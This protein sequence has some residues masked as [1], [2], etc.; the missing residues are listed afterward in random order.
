MK[1]ADALAQ[2]V[3]DGLRAGR[4]P[5]QLRAALLAEGWSAPEVDRALGA[6]ADHGLGLP[7]PRP[8][9]QVASGEAVLY[10]LMFVALLVVIWHLID[11]GFDLISVWLPDPVRDSGGV[12]V[13]TSIRWSIAALVVTVPLFLWLNARVERAVRL[14]PATARAPLRR[15]FGALTLFLAALSLV[16]AAVSVVYGGLMGI[17]TAHFLA[18]TALV[19]VIAVLVI[20]YFRA[21]VAE[22]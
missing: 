20:G 16:G 5:A 6:W 22:D 17:V 10:G 14:D 1:P 4:A 19:V 7:V 11:L 15:R 8:R 9:V 21:Y 3:Q 2:F 12:W 13:N 18:K